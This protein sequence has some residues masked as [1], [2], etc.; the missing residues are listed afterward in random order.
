MTCKI[1]L[2]EGSVRVGVLQHIFIYLAITWETK[3]GGGGGEGGSAN[4]ILD[5]Q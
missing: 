5:S 3:I 2:K 4:E 1:R